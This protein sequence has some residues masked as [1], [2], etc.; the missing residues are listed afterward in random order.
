MLDLLQD[1]SF[2]WKTRILNHRRGELKSFACIE[3][4]IPHFRGGEKK[5][6]ESQGR[7]Q[8]KIREERG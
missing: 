1:R 6:L 4:N 5:R 8:R 3:N 7:R 2:P